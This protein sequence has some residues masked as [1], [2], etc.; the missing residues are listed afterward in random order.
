MVL[1]L[2][3]VVCLLR[4]TNFG[5]ST[6]ATPPPLPV[7][8]LAAACDGVA[9][10]ASDTSSNKATMTHAM[11]VMSFFGRV[12]C[13]KHHTCTTT[14]WS[15]VAY[16][17]CCDDESFIDDHTAKVHPSCCLYGAS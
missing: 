16:L 12:L 10:A 17:F 11:R 15:G 1:L 7:P 6:D 3:L 2:A 4:G 5:T 13:D 9:A 14:K 8:P